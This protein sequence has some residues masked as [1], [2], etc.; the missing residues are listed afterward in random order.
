MLTGRVYAVGI[1]QP[2]DPFGGAGGKA[3]VAERHGRERVHRHP[4]HILAGG[5]GFEGRPLVD[6]RRDRVL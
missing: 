3:G 1:E 5:N 6:L 4:G 2:H